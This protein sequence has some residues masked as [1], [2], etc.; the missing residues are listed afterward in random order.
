M[1]LSDEI[2]YTLAWCDVNGIE[3]PA[4]LLTRIESAGI[5]TYE[6]YRSTIIAAVRSLFNDKTNVEQFI[7]KITTVLSNQFFAA[8]REGMAEN[9]LDTKRDFTQ[10]MADEISVLVNSELDHLRDFALAIIE[11][12]PNEKIDDMLNRGEMWANQYTKVVGIARVATANAGKRFKWIVGDTEHCETCLTLKDVVA[13]KEDW[14]ALRARGIYPKSWELKCHGVHCQ[15]DIVPTDDPLTE[16]SL[17]GIKYDPDQPRDENGRFGSGG[18]GES[19][20][21]SYSSSDF[22]SDDGDKIQSA[23]KEILSWDD[24]RYEIAEAALVHVRDYDQAGAMFHDANKKLVGVASY[25]VGGRDFE[26]FVEIK[27]LATRETGYG[28]KILHD[29]VKIAQSEGKGLILKA[30]KSARAFYEK[31]WN[32]GFGRRLLCMDSFRGF[33]KECGRGARKWRFCW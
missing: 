2:F 13:K 32:D 22:S 12:R 25:E 14:E 11:A 6:Y 21:E 4:D 24:D 26:D 15:C 27:Y 3:I 33:R 23:R 5:K 17:V 19:S 10:A 30:A 7:G 20:S 28:S 18:S 29:F 9:G 8:W 1:P 16:K 31:K